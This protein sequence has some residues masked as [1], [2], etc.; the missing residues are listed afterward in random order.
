VI[1]D[2]PTGTVLFIGRVA[3]PAAGQWPAP[4]STTGLWTFPGGG[5]ARRA[6][7]KKPP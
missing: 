3:H 5:N 7:I 2:V 1:R 4:A 6:V